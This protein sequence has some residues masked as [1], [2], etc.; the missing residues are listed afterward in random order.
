MKAIFVLMVLFSLS[1]LAGCNLKHAA[2]SV[3]DAGNSAG[4][5]IDDTISRDKAK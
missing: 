4:E 5:T 2:K 3:G 1:S